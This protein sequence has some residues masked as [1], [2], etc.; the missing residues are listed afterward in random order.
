MMEMSNDNALFSTIE[1][2]L[3]ALYSL[4]GYPSLSSKDCRMTHE[5]PLPS[6]ISTG[7]HLE[8][9]HS[10]GEAPNLDSLSAF[11]NMSSSDGI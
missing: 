11:L 9:P 5:E 2:G 8:I 7:S 3:G 1:R 6:A 10:P 4:V